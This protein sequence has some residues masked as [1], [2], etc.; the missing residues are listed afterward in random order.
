MSVGTPTEGQSLPGS[1]R[2]RHVPMTLDLLTLFIIA[3]FISAVAGLL[4][5]LSWLQ[6]RN[7]RAL[8][9]WGAA[10]V[11]GSVGVALV[12]ARSDI[13]DVWSIAIANAIVATAYGILWS[14]VRDFEGHPTSVILM[15]AGAAIWLLAC[16]IETF[17]SA[18]LARA[19]LMSA[20]VVVY[21][22]L[23]AWELWQGRAEG[24]MSRW[25]IIVLAAHPRR[26]LSHPSSACGLDTVC[27]DLP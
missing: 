4:L 22:A 5:L 12:S 24:P 20:I 14:G 6:N 21:S 25:P 8:A 17:Y 26:R 23:S 9:F 19:G 2:I 11:I 16:L 3:V 7:V 18:P 10:F 1:A 27:D 13:P 15:L